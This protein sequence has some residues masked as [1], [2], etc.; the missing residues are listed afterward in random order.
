MKIDWKVVSQSAGYI[1]IKKAYAAQLSSANRSNQKW[2][3]DKSWNLE[4]AK[5]RFA[6]IIAR[7]VHYAYHKQTTVDVILNQWEEKRTYSWGSYYGD[8]TFPKL[9]KNSE[10]VAQRSAKSWALKE[11][12]NDPV[13]RKERYFSYLLREARDKRKRKGSKARWD[14]STREYRKLIKRSP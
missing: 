1:S 13:K 8:Q 11:Y 5:K 6:W 14:K 12:P 2:K 4:E 3:H 9:D 7:A 10:H